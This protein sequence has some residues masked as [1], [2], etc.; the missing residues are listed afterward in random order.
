[1]FNSYAQGINKRINRTGS[2]FEK[3]FKRKLVESEDY[4]KRLV[5]YICHNPVHHGFT[6]TIIE[7]PWSSYH[8]IVKPHDTK[9][10]QEEVVDWF[11]DVENFK[12]YHQQEHELEVMKEVLIDL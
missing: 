5:Y 2:L 7:Y 1:M 10:K 3:S 11:D 4:L 12:F 6:D 8:S 9:L